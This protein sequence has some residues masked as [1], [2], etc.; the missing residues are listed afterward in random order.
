MQKIED[1]TVCAAAKAV[2]PLFFG[3]DREGGRALHVEGTKADQRCPA[4]FQRKMTAHHVGQ[5]ELVLD[6]VDIDAAG[7][8]TTRHGGQDHF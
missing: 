8:N 6:R 3:I 4:A 7:F 5:R 1:V 2:E